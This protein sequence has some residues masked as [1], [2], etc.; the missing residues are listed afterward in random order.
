MLNILFI[1]FTGSIFFI[2]N[3]NFTTNRVSLVKQSF[4]RKGFGSKVINMNVVGTWSTRKF[5]TYKPLLKEH[6]LKL[7]DIF[8]SLPS[9]VKD[10]ALY[11][12]KNIKECSEILL[13]MYNNLDDPIVKLYIKNNCL[14]LVP[15]RDGVEG[16]KQINISNDLPS[17]LVEGSDKQGHPYLYTGMSGCYIFYCL[18]T[19]QYYVGSAICFNTR[20]K[21]HKVN[22]SRPERGGSNS[23]YLS[24]EKF[25]W[26]A[27]IWKPILITSN[28]I[29]N[30]TKQNPEHELSL[31]SLFI[32][33]SFTQFE[34][35]L[36][37]Q[38]LLTHLMPSLN[39]TYTVVFPFS[40]WENSP[41][42]EDNSKPLEVRAEDNSLIMKFSSKSRAA[43]S[44]GIPKTTL[45]R[46]IN[47][48]NFTIYSPVLDM[49]VYLIDPFL[50]LSEDSPSYVKSDGM[51]PITGV[52]LYTLE[53]GKLYA[54]LLDKKSLFGIYD[55]PSRAAKD[56]DG[57]SDSR[58]I[59]RYINIE[60]S[61]IVGQDKVSV[62]FVMNPDW[63]SDISSRIGA[64]S[65][66]RT[67]SSLSKSI[68]LVD[69][70]NN[71]SLVFDTVS[72]MSKYLGRKALSDTGYVKKYMNPIKLY[73][74]RYE[75]H[76]L[77]DYSGTISGKG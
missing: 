58:Y 38:F 29:N 76:Y 40:S 37:E 71:N 46:Y 69:T 60:R 24:V 50:P 51:L 77:K 39:S 2:K 73:K 44:L 10:S 59:S 75:F 57:K 65:V 35:R 30:F 74:G 43:V 8:S 11:K 68:V 14:H 19:G 32:L 7:D 34:A 17:Y 70:L 16:I 13:K 31:E 18:K 48:K 67:K 20:Y 53:K 54:L 45:G 12:T 3:I 1:F 72:D 15:L 47:L 41:L 6:N 52:D 5:S 63:K 49:D 66:E 64:R 28:Y 33:R 27:F 25:G 4:E 36:Y 61:V 55:N 42:T 9:V 21:A 22:S 56:L 26:E 23:L 62:Y